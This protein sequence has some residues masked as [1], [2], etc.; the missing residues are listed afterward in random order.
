MPNA[1]KYS[2]TNQSGSI[3]SNNIAI[4]NNNIEYGPT[5]VTGWY[6]GVTPPDNKYVIYEITAS[7][8]PKIY[9]PN[10][11]VQF[12][13][14]ARNKG[15]I[16]NTVAGSIQFFASQSGF[17]IA[18][19]NYPNIVTSG[20]Q[21]LLD[22]SYV[23]S[24]PTTGST[25]YDISGNNTSGSLINGPTFNQ[26][27]GAI[28]LDGID[29]FINQNFYTSTY[30]GIN[31]SWTIDVSL[32]IISS[33]SAGNTR[34]G[35]VTNQ[36]YQTETNPGGFGLNIIS[37][38]YCINLTSGSTGAALTQ[39]VLAPVPINY[40]RNERITALFDSSSS[41]VRIYR[42]G[43]LANSSTSVNY[44]WTPR[45]VGLP[46]RI[47][48]ST[49]GGWGSYFPMKFYNVSLY[50]KALSQSEILQNYY[51]GP[52]VTDGL[53]FA[54]DAGNIVS[55]ESGS[56]ITYSMTGSASGSLI[57]GVGYLPNNGGTWAFDGTDDQISISP[58]SNLNFLGTLPYS[59][60]V[61]GN[62]EATGSGARMMVSRENS[63]GVG[64]DGYNILLTN[65]NS[66]TVTFSAERFASNVQLGINTSLATSSVLNRWAHYVVT[67]DGQFYRLFFNG[68]IVATSSLITSS[69]TNT[70][71]TVS[72]ANR[73]TGLGN[74]INMKIA[75]A[76]IYNTSL[77]PSQV[78]QNFNAQKNRFI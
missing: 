4:G 61:W 73:G 53:V 77:S 50:N 59:I 28:V 66:S 71:S 22:A 46:Q 25:W 43:V 68:T 76:N 52:I 62:L 23:E 64:R 2:T 60:E 63:I 14:L 7:G 13:R 33:Q 17:S 49:Q 38:N 34:G 41:T 67:Y 40:N 74:F 12:I 47:G 19:K 72:I 9:V 31:Q 78:L 55:Y 37:Q 65:M 5:A 15:S 57:N 8:N 70:I 27:Q 6:N 21:L 39:E 3:R 56:T 24:Y 11:D 29:D 42:N 35:V 48:T 16:S 45:S 51:Q 30:Y 18:N 10:D 58:D 75:I 1:V 69:I 20:S 36:L 26:G 54:V 32:N 44:K